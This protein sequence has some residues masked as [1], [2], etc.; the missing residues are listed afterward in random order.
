MQIS[1]WVRYVD[2]QL[3]VEHCQGVTSPRFKT[4]KKNDNNLA[5]VDVFPLLSTATT[6][7]NDIRKKENV[8]LRRCSE[9]YRVMKVA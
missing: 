2:L 5:L 3:H 4:W 1:L 6:Q 7:E 9:H 8:T